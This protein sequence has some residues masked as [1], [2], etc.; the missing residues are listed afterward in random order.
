M[1]KC[2]RSSA[3]PFAGIAHSPVA[4]ASILIDSSPSRLFVAI[5][6]ELPPAKRAAIAAEIRACLLLVREAAR[7][8]APASTL[9]DAVI[10]MVRIQSQI[11]RGHR[12]GRSERYR[13]RR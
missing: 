12:F 8:A 9:A 10:F 11:S 13:F 1:S 3:R 4:S 6:S 7:E 5:E 2:F